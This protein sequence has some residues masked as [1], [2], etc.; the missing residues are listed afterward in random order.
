MPFKQHTRREHNVYMYLDL[1]A[2][3][4][5]KPLTEYTGAEN[6]IARCLK[7]GSWD[8]IPFKTS[9]CVERAEAEKAAAEIGG[10]QRRRSS[11]GSGSGSG[12]SGSALV[13]ES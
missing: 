11:S 7:D 9:L 13:V 1:V 2:T 10:E 5:A 12:G 3:I 6:Y 8:F 4:V